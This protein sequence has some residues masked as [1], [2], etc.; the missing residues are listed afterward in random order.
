[1]ERLDTR[2]S[3]NNCQKCKHKFKFYYQHDKTS[4]IDNQYPCPV[5]GELYCTKPVQERILFK[6]QLKYLDTDREEF[7]TQLVK[8]AFPYIK[9]LFLKIYK[10]RMD[11]FSES[12]DYYVDNALS[13]LVEEYL[14]DPL[15]RIEISFAGYIK[16][17]LR[18]ALYGKIEKANIKTDSLDYQ[19][20][21]SHYVEY[22]D[23]KFKMLEDIEEVENKINLC[24]YIY[25]LLI[26]Y[27]SKLTEQED[28]IR[29]LAILHSLSKSEK[30]VDRLFQ[31]EVKEKDKYIRYETFNKLGKLAFLE[32]MDI[33][34]RELQE[35]TIV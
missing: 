19:H 6:L 32:T 34:K 14:M 5:C 15:F 12:I 10:K 8:E 29:L 23:V 4:W 20:K 26:Q 9:S 25:N 1:M 3:Y 33:F 22:E 16:Y 24:N 31:N 7:Y 11:V 27:N 18:Q 13:F 30:F 17:K 35:L 28:I 21:D 2:G